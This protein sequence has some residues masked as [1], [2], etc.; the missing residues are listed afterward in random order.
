MGMAL[1]RVRKDLAAKQQQHN[2]KV[3]IDEQYALNKS[4]NPFG[5]PKRSVSS[6]AFQ[7]PQKERKQAPSG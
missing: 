4:E 5:L 7:A 1:Q 6:Q 2:V 3:L